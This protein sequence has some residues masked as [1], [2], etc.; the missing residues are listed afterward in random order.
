MPEGRF[1]IH[2]GEQGWRL[3]D[4]NGKTFFSVGVTHLLQMLEQPVFKEKYEG[5]EQ[6]FIETASTRLRR[7]GFNT[8][9]YG[10]VNAE[11][12]GF[13]RHFPFMIQVEVMACHMWL[14]E[15]A[16]IPDIFDPA[17]KDRAAENISSR[18]R[19]LID[20]PNLVGIY[21]TDT[22]VWSRFDPRDRRAMA[23]TYYALCHDVIRS[24]SRDVLIF[25]DRYHEPDMPDEVLSAALP[26]IDVVSVQPLSGITF[27]GR[28][29][30]EL[31]ERTGKPVMIC[32]L[33]VNFP[34][35]DWPKVL[36]PAL[37]NERQAARAFVDYVQ[38]A[39]ASGI[40]LGVHRCSYI[41]RPRDGLLKQ[42]LVRQDDAP[43]RITT[44][45]FKQGL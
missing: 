15:K 13:A 24:H 29:F 34:T 25:G 30:K 43:Y 23:E 22:P 16:V 19:S 17:W 4:P 10:G 8:V 32:D 21:L 42:G 12:S 27:P 35:P 39:R 38:A 36:W 2:K 7:W 26:Y 14:G 40:V 45:V 3:S 33:A 11:H 1:S 20:D 28:F 18:I 5:N 6:R 37:P 41:D 31:H 44:S 9:G